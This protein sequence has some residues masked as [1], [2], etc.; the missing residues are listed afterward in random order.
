LTNEKWKTQ[1]K[2]SEVARVKKDRRK[3]EKIGHRKIKINGEWFI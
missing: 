3:T 2:L 1:K